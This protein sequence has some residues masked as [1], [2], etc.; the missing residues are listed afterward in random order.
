MWKIVPICSACISRSLLACLSF[1]LLMC[2]SYAHLSFFLPTSCDPIH[3]SSHSSTPSFSL[4]HLCPSPSPLIPLPSFP[5][6]LSLYLIVSRTGCL[7]SPNRVCFQY[8]PVHT[9]SLRIHRRV[10]LF[11]RFKASLIPFRGLSLS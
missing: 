7:F 4:S 3:P 8:L 9:P 6:L 1:S 11:T 2:P 10:I 5:S